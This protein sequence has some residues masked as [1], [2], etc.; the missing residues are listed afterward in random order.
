V[1]RWDAFG[2]LAAA[3]CDGMG[4]LPGSGTIARVAAGYSLAMA[5][6]GFTA[7]KARSPV[8]ILKAASELTRA[9]PETA[10]GDTTAVLA[11]IDPV[12]GTVEGAW[13]GDSRLYVYGDD[14]RLHLQTKDH[15]LAAQGAPTVLTRSLLAPEFHD[16]AKEPCT[17][18]QPEGL[19]WAPTTVRP[20]RVVMTTDGVHDVVTGAEMDEQLAGAPDAGHAARR[21]T[22]F[23]LRKAARLAAADRRPRNADNTTAL[24]IDWPLHMA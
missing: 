20:W 16:C 8:A 15:N 22:A 13:V 21:L 7:D 23:A 12:A 11:W 5:A 14:S 10:D 17:E 24:V 3:V 1:W 2:C 18:H 19:S 6:W 9:H 4:S